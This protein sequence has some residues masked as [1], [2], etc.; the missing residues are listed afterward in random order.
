MMDTPLVSICCLSYNHAQF[1][2]K[3]L[4][5]FLMQKTDFPVEILVHD[6]ASTDGTEAIVR[7][8]EVK[9]PD[10]I[11]PLYET[12]NKYTH[13]YKGKMD[14]AFNYSRA[15][16]KYIAYCEGD[17]YWTDPL[18]LQKQVDFLESHPDYSVCFT[19]CRKYYVDK[20]EYEDVDYGGCLEDGSDGVDIS[21][22]MYFSRWITQPLTMVFRRDSFSYEWQKQYK[23]YRDMHEIYHLLQSG[24]GR[25]M[26]FDGGV[27]Q[28]HSGGIHSMIGR[29]AYYEGSLP[30]DEEFYHLNPNKWSKAVYLDTL[31][32]GI[33]VFR[34]ENKLKAAGVALRYLATSHNLKRF[35]KHLRYIFL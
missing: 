28:C 24:K 19:K 34:R 8:Y 5:G 1:I 31:Q 35:V 10:K 33:D 27:Y 29:K 14:I 3:C 18:K 13:G 20:K 6:D 11:F 32:D 16:G 12:E 15:R 17:D 22:D 2:G 9:Y 26:N 21:L 7:E 4:D 23:Y 25:L 30:I